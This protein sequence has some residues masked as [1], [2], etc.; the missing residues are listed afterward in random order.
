MSTAALDRAPRIDAHPAQIY[1]LTTPNCPTSPKVVRDLL[2]SL[3]LVT[4][5]PDLV[6][7]AQVC[8]S[9]VVTNVVQHTKVP[10]MHID[11]TIQDD[12]VIVG[13]RDDDPCG[14]PEIRQASIKDETRR[15]LQLVDHLSYAWDVA[16]TGA[17]GNQTGKRVW[18]ELRE[19]G[20]RV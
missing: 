8:A 1:H 18:F 19:P 12:R 13:V 2:A 4:G 17:D 10:D 14:H 16:W 5:H 9:D 20:L 7:A 15:G 11:V 6:D 3:L